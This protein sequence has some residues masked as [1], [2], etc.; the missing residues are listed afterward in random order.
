MKTRLL[1]LTVLFTSGLIFSNQGFAQ[2]D[3]KNQDK[4]H[5]NCIMDDLT[6][7]QQKKIETIKAESDKKVV[8]YR[9]DLKIKNAELDKLMVAENPA[10]KDIDSKIDEISVLKS[11]I[12]KENVNRRLLIRNEL[13]PEQKVKFD[14]M[15]AA[16]T[17][18]KAC[19]SGKGDGDMHK[20]CG[21]EGM[22]NNGGEGQMHK[23]CD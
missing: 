18:G 10:K 5:K 19:C 2:H 21:K 8:Q 4:A 9:A 6:P 17:D 22:H 13:T 1:F 7:D 23:N 16:K 12:Q 14:A 15:H 3:C 20:G 11:N